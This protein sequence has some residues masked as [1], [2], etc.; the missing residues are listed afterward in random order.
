M[1]KET[2]EKLNTKQRNAVDGYKTLHSH[3]VDN[4]KAPLPGADVRIMAMAYL[5]GLSDAG[6]LTEAEKEEIFRYII[7]DNQQNSI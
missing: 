3:A 7:F 2:L 5:S 4:D 6:I 1:T